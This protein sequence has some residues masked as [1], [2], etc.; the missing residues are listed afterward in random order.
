M[1]GKFQIFFYYHAIRQETGRQTKNHHHNAPSSED[2]NKTSPTSLAPSISTTGN[3]IPPN[4]TCSRSLFMRPTDSKEIENI[5]QGMKTSQCEDVFGLSTKTIKWVSNYISRPLAALFNTAMENGVFHNKLK[6]ARITPV[7]K[8][9]GEERNCENYRPIAVLPAV[10][11]IFEEIILRRIHDHFNKNQLFT[12][13]QFAYQQGKST[14]EAMQLLM[15]SV[16]NAIEQR[17]KCVAQM[18]DLSRAFDSIPHSLLLRKM[19]MYG[20]RGT[21]LGLI[22]SYLH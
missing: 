4:K 6:I 16:Y 3:T 22:E 2:F 17:E 19:D 1:I 20:I 21:P 11:K 7:Y 14:E 9:K 18:C 8:K 5:I 13:M 12:P 15:R 10:S